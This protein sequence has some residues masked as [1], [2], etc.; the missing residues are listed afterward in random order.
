MTSVSFIVAQTRAYLGGDK[1]HTQAE[2]LCH[3]GLSF[4]Q[5]PRAAFRHPGSEVIYHRRVVS[6]SACF[7]VGVLSGGNPL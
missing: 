4:L 3:P 6:S 2:V 5:D 1:G 7:S